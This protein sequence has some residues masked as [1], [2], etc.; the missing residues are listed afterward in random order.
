MGSRKSALATKD[1]VIQKEV[2]K[3]KSKV[4]LKID[5]IFK[6]INPSAFTADLFKVTWFKEETV[7][8]GT[9]DESQRNKIAAFDLVSRFCCKLSHV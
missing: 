7:L 5:R 1:K 3:N 4:P 6:V 2:V 9:C 8:I